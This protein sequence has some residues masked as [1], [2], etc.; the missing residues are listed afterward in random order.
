MSVRAEPA[1]LSAIASYL[2]RYH[3]HEVIADAPPSEE[4]TPR[5]HGVS[6]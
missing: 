3:R 6:R 1:F 5:G 2:R 4:P